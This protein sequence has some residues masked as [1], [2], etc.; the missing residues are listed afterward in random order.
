MLQKQSFSRGMSV[1]RDECEETCDYEGGC[2]N[3]SIRCKHCKEWY[4]E[5][6]LNSDNRCKICVAKLGVSITCEDCEKEVVVNF[7]PVQCPSC[8][9]KKITTGRV[10]EDMWI[11]EKRKEIDEVWR[12]K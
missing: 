11:E 7:L 4:P 9:S 5:D 6:E 8:E 12:T 10:I 2:C 1:F 3:C